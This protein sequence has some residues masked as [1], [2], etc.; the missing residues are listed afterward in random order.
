MSKLSLRLLFLILFVMYLITINACNNS[1][2]TNKR[3]I[4]LLDEVDEVTINFVYI[5][6]EGEVNINS[7][8][9]SFPNYAKSIAIDNDYIYHLYGDVINIYYR[10]D[11]KLYKRIKIEVEFDSN[12]ESAITVDASSGKRK[13]YLVINNYFTYTTWLDELGRY[14]HKQMLVEIDDDGKFVNEYFLKAG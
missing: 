7:S 5:P 10:T 14:D 13:I 12:I 8:D 3:S 1:S 9:K 2:E 11:Y 6:F 4:G